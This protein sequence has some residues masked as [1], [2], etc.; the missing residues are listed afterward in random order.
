MEYWITTSKSDDQVKKALK[1]EGLTGAALKDHPNYKKL[2]EFW[3][4]LEGRGMDISVMLG[5]RTYEFWYHFGLA[6]MNEAERQSSDKFRK[7]LRYAT[8][9]DNA[10]WNRRNNIFHPPKIYY[11]VS[12]DEMKVIIQIWV[13]AKRTNSYVKKV[14]GLDGFSKAKRQRYLNNKYFLEFLK[15]TERSER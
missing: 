15:L 8:K 5:T 2:E 6:R 10:M 13:K 12:P 9:Y 1:M 11:D 4:K 3:Y 7:Y 14:L